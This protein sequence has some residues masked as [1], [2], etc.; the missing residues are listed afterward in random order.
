VTELVL[1]RLLPM[2]A[3]GLESWDV[4]PGDAKRLLRI[5]E[6]RCLSARTGATWQSEAVR[7]LTDRYH[8]GRPEA[9]RLMTLGYIERMQTHEPVHSWPD[10]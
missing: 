3:D 10:M 9:L 2:A 4:D 6:Q 5:I 7:A 8:V 1:R